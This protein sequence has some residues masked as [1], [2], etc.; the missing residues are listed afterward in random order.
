MQVLSDGSQPDVQK[1]SV[2]I[3][4]YQLPSS[5][6]ALR[7][8]S[9]SLRKHVINAEHMN[10]DLFLQHED[11]NLKDRAKATDRIML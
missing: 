10:M 4:H 9:S 6:P 11:Y 7:Q 8:K 3:P 5:M 2:V 1:S